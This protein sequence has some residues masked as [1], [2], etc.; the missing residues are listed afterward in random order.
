MRRALAVLATAAL[1]GAGAMADFPAVN[2]LPARPE[3]PDPLVSLDGKKV[4]TKEQ[5]NAERRPELQKLFQHYMYGYFP[6][7]PAEFRHRVDRVD[8]A[9]LGGKATLKEVTLTLGAGDGKTRDVHL[10][11]VVPN[12]RAGKVPVIFGL[13]FTGNH[14]VLADPKIRLPLTWIAENRKGVK[15]NRASDEGRGTAVDTWSIEQTIDAG[16]AVATVYYGDVEPDRKD[17]REG[18]QAIF[19]SQDGPTNWGTVAAWAWGISRCLD[20]LATEPDLDMSRVVVMGHS[21]LGKATLLAAA[22]DLRIAVAI[23]HQAG[24][25]GTAPNRT[26]NPKSETVKVINKSF[27]HWFNG[28][29]KEFGEQVERLPFDQHCLLACVAPR[30]VLYSNA[31]DDQWANPDGQFEML[32]AADP[33]YKLLGSPGLSAKT[34]P[35]IGTLVDSPLGYFIRAGKHSVT[36]EDWRMFVRFADAQWKRK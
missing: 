30:P 1:V 36:P 35:E 9:A 32:A 15:N 2:Q 8:P 5:W 6:G 23:P 29:F 27:P 18:V 4:T 11:L 24:C 26:R 25:G 22:F 13:N 21:R 12:K 17:L 7:K 20:Y 3:L 14:S 31:L 33:V 16:Y 34:R 10:L 28:P 19:R